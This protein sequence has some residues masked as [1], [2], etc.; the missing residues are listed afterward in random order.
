MPS[1]SSPSMPSSSQLPDM[2]QLNP[3]TQLSSDDP[4]DKHAVPDAKPDAQP[5]APSQTPDGT[6]A[7]HAIA[8]NA[9]PKPGDAVR[10]GQLGADG[11]PLDKDGDGK[12][13]ADAVA[14]TKEN[15]DPDGDGVPNNFQT[16][17]NAD[18]RELLV[19]CDDPRLAEM[20]QRMSEA[21]P[22]SPMTIMDAADAS[23]LSLNGY[24]TEI[25]VLGIKPGDVVTGMDRGLYLGEGNVLTESGEVK[26]LS[27]V[28]DVYNS[29]PKVHRLELPELPSSSEVIPE[30][31]QAAAESDTPM[32][33]NSESPTASVE[34][35]NAASAPEPAAPVV[36]PA[37]SVHQEPEPAAPQASPAAATVPS[38]PSI[39][40]D[41]AMPVE[42]EYEGHA[43]G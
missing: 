20:M 30:V 17:V 15:M 13:D 36:E 38:E 18:G 25:D 19:S 23:G 10:P 41:A 28:M 39:P 35:A 40:D 42:V 27:D 26:S 29:D 1:M 11:R 6:A 32:A 22:D 7:T 5:K 12:M 33:A 9:I 43:I 2:S 21:S 31:S 16:M 34:Q 3:D 24:G 4:K 14:P 8:Q 37:S